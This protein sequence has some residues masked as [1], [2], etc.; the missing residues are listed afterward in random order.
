MD[1]LGIRVASKIYC[2]CLCAS[3]LAPSY[4]LAGKIGQDSTA[5]REIA[6]RTLP[7]VVLVVMVRGA[8][9][10]T[11]LGSG[12]FVG[13]DVIATNYHVVKDATRGYVKGVDNETRYDVIGLV[14]LDRANDLALLKVRK[15][16]GVALRLADS[17]G[18]EVGDSI[19]VVSNP[20]GLEGTFST[21]IISS[22]RKLGASTVVQI[23][24]P[25]SHGSS[26]G[27]V[28]NSQGEVI[29][30]A[31]GAIEGGQ[32][33]NFA[34][35]SSYLIDLL[36]KNSTLLPLGIA[37]SALEVK[38]ARERRVGNSPSADRVPGML[39]TPASLRLAKE[40]DVEH[41]KLRGPVKNLRV[42][43]AKFTEKFG[44][45]EK[46]APW[47]VIIH[48]FDK[49]GFTQ[50]EEGYNYQDFYGM[51][52]LVEPPGAWD[53][54]RYKRA[55]TYDYE[56]R[57][58]AMDFY[59]A[60]LTEKVLEYRTRSIKKYDESG[61]IVDSSDYNPDGSLKGKLVYSTD[62]R[63]RFAES[64]YSGDGKKGWS[65]IK[66]V[67]AAGASVEE[68]YNSSNK[69]ISRTTKLRTQTS[70]GIIEI[71]NYEP[72]ETISKWVALINPK[73][74]LEVERT[75]YLGDEVI[76]RFKFKYKFDSVG[77]WVEEVKYKEVT[78]F[79]KTYFEPETVTL[80]QITYYGA[81]PVSPRRR[82]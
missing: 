17:S 2:L 42:E 48:T 51:S 56:E 79:G 61:D 16:Q 59:W 11:V 25:I 78:K 58:S 21:G 41:E 27:P 26:G 69:L 57:T 34:V 62:S 72:G 71:T 68:D 20:E 82:R 70:E 32:A 28:L 39:T 37:S 50:Y 38:A 22:V 64:R 3:L 66:Y 13:T 45:W 77:N 18:A 60:P 43:Q 10:R 30:V 35:P 63:G 7:S 9:D 36:R 15:I 52:E 67:D 19:Y 33:L 81:D 8:S 47:V 73:T 49:Y 14:G 80:R 54:S 31:V 55:Y 76:E 1:N 24:A 6:K 46:T 23:T 12:F 74:R 29:G 5:P 65:T 4:V 53:P 40:T 75:G 44:K